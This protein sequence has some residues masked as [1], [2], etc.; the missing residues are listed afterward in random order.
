MRSGLLLAVLITLGCAHAPEPEPEP[1]R[2][3][4]YY[5]LAMGHAWTFKMRPSPPGSNDSRT[6][7]IR[8]RG[9]G[10][11]YLTDAGMRLSSTPS[12]VMDG[13]RI[14]LKE[15][16]EV[17]NTW[18]V[19][20]TATDVERYEIIEIGYTK[21]VTAGFFKDCVRV[22]I[23]QDVKGPNGESGRLTGVWTYA[24]GMGPIHFHQELSIEGRPPRPTV[25]FELMRFD[26]GSES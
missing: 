5:P 2:A 26:A 22:R 16:L 9:P 14:L 10:G 25:E 13:E 7:T 21:Q 24:R 15:P 3:A 4:D 17:G 1:A 8:E 12:K 23:E 18:T 11:E 20:P 19:I 6:I